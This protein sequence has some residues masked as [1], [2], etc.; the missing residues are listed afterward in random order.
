MRYLEPHPFKNFFQTVRLPQE[1]RSAATLARHL[2]ALDSALDVVEGRLTAVPWLGGAAFS[3]ADIALGSLMYRYTDMDI[4]RPA[5]PGLARWH[6]ALRERPAFR[7][8]I[9]TSYDDLR[10]A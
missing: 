6:A 1:K 5:R 8:V 10:G 2:E 3:V 7:A 4:P 9:E